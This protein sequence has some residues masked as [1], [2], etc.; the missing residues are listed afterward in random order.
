MNRIALRAC[1]LIVGFTIAGCV[2]SIKQN[3]SSAA[4]PDPGVTVPAGAKETAGNPNGDHA[5]VVISVPLAHVHLTATRYDTAAVPATVI[6]Y[7]RNELSRLGPVAE[8]ER[9][10]HTSIQS[11]KWQQ[12]PHDITLHAGHTAVAIAP[13]GSGTEFAIIVVN[14]VDARGKEVQ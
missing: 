7:Y 11:F 4:T 9:G 1:A 10:P 8:S 2:Y 13:H 12:G 5:D 14:V 3:A 6:A